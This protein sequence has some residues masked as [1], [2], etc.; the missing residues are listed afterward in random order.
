MI[1]SISELDKL[2]FD[3]IQEDE[4][5]NSR[6]EKETKIHKV[7]IYPAK[8]PSLIAQKAFTYAERNKICIKRVADI[9]CGCGTVAVEARRK[10]YDF[11]GCDINPVAVLLSNVKTSS[12]DLELVNQYYIEILDNYS[13]KKLHVSDKVYQDANER[14]QYWFTSKQYKDL[15]ALKSAIQET[16]N[17]QRYLDLYFCIFSSILKSTSKWLTSSIKPQVDPNKSER[18]VIQVFQ[19]QYKN[20]VDAI[21]EE[22]YED[23]NIKIVCEN[24]LDV[25]KRNSVDMIITSPPYVTSYEYADLHQLST[26]WLDYINDYKELRAES[27][28]TQYGVKSNKVTKKLTNTAEKI[29][30]Y[31]PDGSQ[32]NSIGKYY[33]DMI[34]VSKICYRL[35]RDKGIC[36]FVIGDTEYK[37]KKIENARCLAESLLQSGFVI[38]EITKRRIENKFLPSHR[39]IN[40]KFSSSKDD[41][42]IYSQEYVII[43]RK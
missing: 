28:G 18:D 39:D 43:A 4:F 13:A 9:F 40:G 11:W 23:S 31:F 17:E 25:K 10:G 42:K 20:F 14:L 7:H 37:Q 5:W 41:R 16:V 2:N 22:D 36:V 24:V 1:N 27:I 3:L 34:K 32:K 29:I 38:E 35:L 30:K 21:A 8:F 19:K 26:L 33:S 12:Y 6:D 15:Y